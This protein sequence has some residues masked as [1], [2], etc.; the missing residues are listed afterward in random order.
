MTTEFQSGFYTQMR[1]AAGWCVS[2]T[3]R[4]K[5][6]ITNG[7]SHNMRLLVIITHSKFPF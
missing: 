5:V 2:E 6:L 4:R 3:M 7:E 1:V